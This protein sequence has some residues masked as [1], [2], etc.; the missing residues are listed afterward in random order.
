MHKG[1]L[2]PLVYL[3]ASLVLA[4]ALHHSLPVTRLVPPS[5]RFAGVGLI[6]LGVALIIAPALIFRARRTAI[7]PFEESSVLIQEGLYGFSRNPIYLGMVIISLGVAVLL[8]SASSFAAPVGL[9]AV[10]QERFI[11]VEERMLEDRFGERYRSYRARVRR[12][13]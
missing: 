3:L 1:K 12:W 4:F 9:F 6:V 11:R 8:G 7:M 5:L 2:L 10:L 13:L